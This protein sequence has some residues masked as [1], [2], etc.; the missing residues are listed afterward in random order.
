MDS[1]ADVT[2]VRTTNNPANTKHLYNICTTLYKCYTNVL[3]F[4]EER[5]SHI[6]V[7]G[8]HVHVAASTLSPW[9]EKGVPRTL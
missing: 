5:Y 8:K 6:D 7:E 1:A 2:I 3:L 9:N 4:W